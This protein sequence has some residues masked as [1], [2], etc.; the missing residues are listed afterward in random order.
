VA[1]ID[2][3]FLLAVVAFG[4][5]LSLASY[6]LFAT[7]HRWPM[8]AWQAEWP[9]L[10]TTLGILCMLVAVL[11]AVARAYGGYVLSAGSIPLFGVAWA[12]F[13]TGFLR[14]GAQSALLLAPAAALV[15]LWR[16]IG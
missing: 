1:G 14:V 4:W 3:G 2:F 6:R 13:W 11:F 5:G 8:G 7:Q 15:L 16:W 9:A 10:T 12:V